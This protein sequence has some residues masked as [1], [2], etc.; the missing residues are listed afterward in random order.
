MRANILELSLSSQ[1]LIENLSSLN[2]F[3][4]CDHV[5]ANGADMNNRYIPGR[6]D[7][8][9]GNGFTLNT[10]TST[11][12][13]VVKSVCLESTAKSSAAELVSRLGLIPGQCVAM[14]RGYSRLDVASYMHTHQIGMLGILGENLKYDHPATLASSH[15]D[16]LNNI[17]QAKFPANTILSYPGVGL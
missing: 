15:F 10:V 8:R 5:S 11:T 1:I 17:D 4:I 7:K 14:D 13:S 9:K 12:D 3:K 16:Q 6:V 2:L